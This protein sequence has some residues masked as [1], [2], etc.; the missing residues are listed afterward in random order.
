MHKR[1]DKLRISQISSKLFETMKSMQVLLLSSPTE[2]GERRLRHDNCAQETAK[3]RS[4]RID[5]KEWLMSV[6]RA[7]FLLLLLRLA[8]QVSRHFVSI[9]KVEL[10]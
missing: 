1:I 8:A 3:S 7:T 10:H 9:E 2:L 5:R 6:G 4:R